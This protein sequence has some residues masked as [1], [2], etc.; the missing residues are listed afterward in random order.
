VTLRHLDLVDVDQTIFSIEV[1]S[2]AAIRRH[3]KVVD[4]LV[5]IDVCEPKA[6]VYKFILLA[7]S[8]LYLFV[9]P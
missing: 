2:G 4:A 7:E 3:A 8:L 6:K 9:R 1:A 5:A